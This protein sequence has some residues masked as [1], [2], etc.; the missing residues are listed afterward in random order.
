[1]GALPRLYRAVPFASLLVG[2]LVTVAVLLLRGAGVLQP[3]ELTIF[4][5]LIRSQPAGGQPD[6]RI[7]LITVSEQDIREEG[8]YPITDATL[9][10]A[11]ERLAED[12]ARAIGL[13]IYRDFEVPPGRNRLNTVL[14]TY[15]NIVAAMKVGNEKELGTPPPKGA[16]HVGFTD[17]VVDSDGTVRRGLLFLTSGDQ[18]VPSLGLQVA[19]MFLKHE[20]VTPAPD[21][22]NP[23]HLRLGEVTFPPFEPSDGGYVTADA[24]GYQ[25]LLDFKGIGTVPSFSLSQLL[26]GKIAPQVIQDKVVLI[27]V[28]AESVPDLFNVPGGQVIPWVA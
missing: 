6:G 21:P 3:V 27:G 28:I 25:V 16:P 8:R 17:F 15:P 11:L 1:M 23:E 19:T 14:T 5:W 12:G 7:V 22:D 4:D 10:A 24:G 2:L 9:A 13:D 20:G 26:S 18:V